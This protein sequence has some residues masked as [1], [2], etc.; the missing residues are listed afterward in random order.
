[1]CTHMDDKILTEHYFNIYSGKNI[2][3]YLYIFFFIK[4]S[5][6]R[7]FAEVGSPGAKE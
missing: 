5:H 6:L 4:K 3:I 2:Y 1:M 7:L